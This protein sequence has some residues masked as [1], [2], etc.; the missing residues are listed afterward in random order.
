MD[1]ESSVPQES[2]PEITRANNSLKLGDLAVPSLGHD[3]TFDHFRSKLPLTVGLIADGHPM[4][5]RSGRI[6]LKSTESLTS[7]MCSA[8]SEWI[9]S[10]QQHCNSALSDVTS[11]PVDNGTTLR[12]PVLTD[13]RCLVPLCWWPWCGPVA[14]S[15]GGYAEV[16]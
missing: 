13:S 12:T 14:I 10:Y 2:A 16:V 6:R 9:I 15:R 5:F 11:T 3:P 1:K 4:T 8:A 7:G